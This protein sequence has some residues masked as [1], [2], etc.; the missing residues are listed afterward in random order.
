L[1]PFI[2]LGPSVPL[3]GA[4]VAVR[5]TSTA[6]WGG[7]SRGRRR[8]RAGCSRAWAAGEARPGAGGTPTRRAAPCFRRLGGLIAQHQGNVS[9]AARTARMDRNHLRE[10]LR[11]HDIDPKRW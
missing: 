2:V 9:A 4:Y 8:C 1:L 6:A 11:R 5:T 7:G 10:L 3:T